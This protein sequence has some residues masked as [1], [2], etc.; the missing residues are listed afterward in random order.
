[1]SGPP[2][3]AL[4]IDVGGTKIAGGVVSLPEGRIGAQRMIPTSPE[5]GG[6][7]VLTEV[8]RLAEELAA[9]TRS[10]GLKLGGVGVGLCELVDPR[11]RILSANCVRWDDQSV[12]QRLAHLGPVIIEADVRAAALAEAHFG[13]GKTFRNFLYVTVGTGISCCLMLEGEPYF[14]ARGATGTM[15]S[16]PF[17]LPCEK[18]GHVSRRSLEELASGPALVARYNARSSAGARSGPEVLAAAEAGDADAIDVVH[19]AGEALGANVGFLVNVLDPE[20]VVVGGGLGLSE[21]PYWESFLASTRRHLWSAVHRE[22]PILRAATG[23]TS[24]LI[25]AAAAAWI[26]LR[27]APG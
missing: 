11:G 23:P 5:R 18:C 4:G 6:A 22:L 15:A 27:E 26:R 17:S 9:T 14:G 16:S 25:G 10:A 12:R 2:F 1:M 3:I 8:V 20:S 24:G 13:A 7:A 19:S 21:G